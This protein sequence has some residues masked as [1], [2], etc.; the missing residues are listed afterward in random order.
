MKA[1]F[2]WQEQ[3]RAVA[4]IT[5]YNY[6]FAVWLFYVLQT[7]KCGTQWHQGGHTIHIVQIVKSWDNLNVSLISTMS[8]TLKT[9]VSGSYIIVLEE[10]MYNFPFP[11]RSLLPMTLLSLQ[12]PQLKQHVFILPSAQHAFPKLHQKPAEESNQG[13]HPVTTDLP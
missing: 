3:H 4:K 9:L 10:R 12:L 8:W 2:K 13:G 11:L 1:L 7:T 6:N 5:L